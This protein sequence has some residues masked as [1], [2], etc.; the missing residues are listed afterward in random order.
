MQARSLCI[1]LFLHGDQM[2]IAALWHI[3]LMSETQDWAIACLGLLY[4]S[5][6]NTSGRVGTDFFLHCQDSVACTF[7][8]QLW[9]DR[10][11]QPY[12]ARLL[13]MYD[14]KERGVYAELSFMKRTDPCVRIQGGRQCDSWPGLCCQQRVQ[15]IKSAPKMTEWIWEPLQHSSCLILEWW[16]LKKLQIN[17]LWYIEL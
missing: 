12:L 9:A 17:C 8:N 14:C 16:L 3:L 11:I 15:W 1:P 6:E 2:P 5:R 10:W 13:I 7:S 4:M